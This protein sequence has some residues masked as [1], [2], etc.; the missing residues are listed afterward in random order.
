MKKKIGLLPPDD[1]FDT[2]NYK[3]VIE[4][5]LIKAKDIIE[6]TMDEI[7]NTSINNIMG[8]EDLVNSPSH[9]TA[10]KVDVID[11]IEDYISDFR[12]ANVVKYIARAGRKHPDKFE[13]DIKKAQWYLNRYVEKEFRNN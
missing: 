5:D 3:C 1:L 2:S 12:L 6:N 9:Y 13:E 7:Q 4:E 11:F 10:G 8:K